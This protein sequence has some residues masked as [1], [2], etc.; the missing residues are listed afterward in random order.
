MR[1]VHGIQFS[2]LAASNFTTAKSVC[3]W[4]G[5]ADEKD[6]SVAASI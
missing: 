6:S 3:L 1:S 4:F 5:F 2:S